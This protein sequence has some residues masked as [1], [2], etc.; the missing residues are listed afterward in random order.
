MNKIKLGVCSALLVGNL[1]GASNLPVYALSNDVPKVAQKEASSFKDVP[2]NYYAYEAIMW[3]KNKGLISGYTGSDGKPNGNFGPNDDVTE[4]QFVKLVSVYFGLK[5]TA[6]DIIKNGASKSKSHWSDSNYDAIARYGAP[7]K[8]YFDINVRNQPVKRGTVAQV[9]GYLMG[10][11]SNLTG[12]IN[13]LLNTGITQGQNPQYEGKDLNKFFGST[14]NLTRSQVV[15]FLYRI[16]TKSLNKL[17]ESSTAYANVGHDLNTK[18]NSAMGKLDTILGGSNKEVT[19]DVEK[20]ESSNSEKPTVVVDEKANTTTTT[21]GKL[22][23]TTPGVS[24]ESKLPKDSNG[25]IIVTPVID[26]TSKIE[27]HKAVKIDNSLT[28]ILK[29]NLKNGENYK[30]NAE[31]SGMESVYVYD[32]K[33]DASVYYVIKYPK[34]TS[35]KVAKDTGAKYLFDYTYGVYLEYFLK[36]RDRYLNYL[37]EYGIVDKEKFTIEDLKTFA[38][39]AST[40]PGTYVEYVDEELGLYGYVDGHMYL[41]INRVLK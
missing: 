20:S 2:M 3:G 23:V 30:T 28:P 14:N 39:K 31:G 5:D 1:V 22:V 21:V 4:A 19:K 10:N 27:K 41:N 7:L 32:S 18:A 25:D 12:S 11:R 29:K 17:G 36:D 24:A 37:F 26:G 8:G 9:F 6:G 33:F 16:D 38:D 34:E 13:Y 15:A 40:Q 35:E